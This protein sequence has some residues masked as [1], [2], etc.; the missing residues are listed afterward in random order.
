MRRNREL[1]I[2]V[3]ATSDPLVLDILKAKKN[4]LP[5]IVAIRD[6][7]NAIRCSLDADFLELAS[8]ASAC[9]TPQVIIMSQSKLPM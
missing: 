6:H 5:D 4:T 1:K 7:L 3:T 8:P 9:S 2:N